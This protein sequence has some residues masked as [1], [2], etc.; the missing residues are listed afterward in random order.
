[1]ST[2]IDGLSCSELPSYSADEIESPLEVIDSIL[3]H[4][5]AHVRQLVP[6]LLVEE[7]ADAISEVLVSRGWAKKLD[8]GLAPIGRHFEPGTRYGVEYTDTEWSTAYGDVQG[9]ECFHQLAMA[10][11]VI[12]FFSSMLRSEAVAHPRRIARIGFPDESYATPPHRDRSFNPI[13]TDVLTAWIPLHN[14]SVESGALIVRDQ[15]IR[16]ILSEPVPHREYDHQMQTPSQ[17]GGRWLYAD[18]EPGDMI[19]FHSSSVHATLPNRSTQIRL[20]VDYRYQ[21]IDDPIYWAALLPHGFTRGFSPSWSQL[22]ADWQSS[23]SRSIS[24]SSVSLSSA[25]EPVPSRLLRS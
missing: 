25:S 6:R 9:L 18:L 17:L 2:R 11:R 23:T 7:V 8:G 19:V 5:A 12:D 4:G 13:P 22:T 15:D 3:D 20:S 1:M 16:K 21:A 24:V 10:S 14:C